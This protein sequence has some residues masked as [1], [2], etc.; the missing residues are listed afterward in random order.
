MLGCKREVDMG[1]ETEV[2][3]GRTRERDEQTR[4][5]LERTHDPSR[6]LALSDGVSAIIITLLVLEIHVPELTQGQSL[7][8]ALAEVRPSLTAFVISFI[9]ASIFR[10]SRG[11]ELDGQVESAWKVGQVCGVG[12]WVRISRSW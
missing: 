7:N 11:G 2:Q 9:L 12:R 3:V 1:D 10:E 8:E 5:M 6:V 4:A